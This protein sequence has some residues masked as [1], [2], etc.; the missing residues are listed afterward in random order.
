MMLC[1][2]LWLSSPGAGAQAS[3]RPS[4]SH[5]SKTRLIAANGANE[6]EKLGQQLKS[7]RAKIVEAKSCG[8]AVNVYLEAA[9]SLDRD[10]R[11]GK[12]TR[13]IKSRADMLTEMLDKQI[14]RIK[15]IAPL[16]QPSP[17]NTKK[18][19]GDLA[20][21]SPA[22]PDKTDYR[23]YIA[24]VQGQVKKN[25]HP[26]KIDHDYRMTV[27]FEISRTGAISNIKLANPSYI[28]AF[29]RAAIAAVEAAAPLTYPKESPRKFINFQFLF[30]YNVRN[31]QS[32]QKKTGNPK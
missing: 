19:A 30:D 25:W 11:A 15:K 20:P 26:P 1:T 18:Y 13:D 2:S 3:S 24:Y 12:E 6:E 21:S 28:P 14:A 31:H 27:S 4:E 17:I 16:K 32:D 23:P 10:Y 29:D 9:D 22:T 7:I 5:T 8:A